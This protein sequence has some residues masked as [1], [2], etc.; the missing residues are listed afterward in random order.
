MSVKRWLVFSFTMFIIFVA[1]GYVIAFHSGQVSESQ[2]ATNVLLALAGVSL[3]SWPVC[4]A[5][6]FQTYL[7]ERARR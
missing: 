7:K 5:R 3:I 6:A 4:L 1:V 2:T